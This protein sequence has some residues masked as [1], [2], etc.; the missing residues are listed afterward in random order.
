MVASPSF[1][2][3]QAS[4]AGSGRHQPVAPMASQLSGSQ[5]LAVLEAW[6]SASQAKLL[7]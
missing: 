7:A 3:M 1:N 6:H 2:M 4:L 5:P